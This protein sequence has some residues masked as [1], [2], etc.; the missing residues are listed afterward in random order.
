MII[1]NDADEWQVYFSDEG[2]EYWYN[3][4]TGETSWEK[5]PKM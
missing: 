4:R 2:H 1:E 3:E 5:P